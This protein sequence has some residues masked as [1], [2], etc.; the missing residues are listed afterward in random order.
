VIATA[1]TQASGRA[2][3]QAFVEAMATYG[4]PDEVLTDNGKQFTARFGRGSGEV[5]FDRICRKNGITHRLT[6]PRSPTTT[7]KIERW[8]QS[9]Q[10]ELLAEAGAF[11][12]VADAQAAI[13]SWREGYNRDRPHQSLDMA[14]PGDRFT[15]RSA[16]DALALWVPPQ[17][18]ALDRADPALPFP[19]APGSQVP[20]TASSDAVEVDR[21]VP[22]SGNLQ[23][24]QSAVLVR[25]PARRRPGEVVDRH[26][27]RSRS[28]RWAA[29]QDA[30]VAAVDPGP[31]PP[32]SRRRPSCR[33]TTRPARRRAGPGRSRRDRPHR[34]PQRCRVQLPIG[35]PLAGRR[36][37]L[38]L[39]EHTAHVIADGQLWRS[40]PFTLPAAKRARLQGARQPGPPPAPRPGPVRVQRRVSSRG[41]IQVIGQ[42]V[43]VGI[44]HAG[45]TATVDVDEHILR[46]LDDNNEALS[47][48]ARANPADPTRL[49][50]YGRRSG[51]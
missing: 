22:T 13:D 30:A 31:G 36:V 50:V 2:V 16:N 44:G 9:I 49:K 32:S 23:V 41:G 27:H 7:G 39:E 43:H 29:P 35:S 24:A 46:V 4:V 28:D 12:T 45:Q 3:C 40:V 21:V 20:L 19:P 14:F 51:T 6:R 11:E 1:V 5:L 15:A 18:E 8:H 26:H 42:R 47:V 37:T 38:R 33:A 34:Q 25:S 48:V 10:N 17:L